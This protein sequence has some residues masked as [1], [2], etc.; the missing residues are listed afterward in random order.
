LVEWN[1]I[2]GPAKIMIQEHVAL[3]EIKLCSAFR[4][5]TINFILTN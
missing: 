3:G 5:I 2:P 4:H 1:V